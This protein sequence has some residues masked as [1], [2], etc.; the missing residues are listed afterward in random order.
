MRLLVAN[1]GEIAVRIM[2]AASELG[3]ETVA[4]YSEDDARALHPRRADAA[5]ALQ[6]AGA[7]AYLDVDQLLAAA[8]EHRC[9]A[10]HPGYGFLSEQA[11]FARACEDA[12]LT[13]VGPSPDS[14]TTF[15]DKAR[16][17]AL[18]ESLGVPVLRGASTAVSLE[19]AQAFLKSLGPGACMVIKAVAGGGGRG[20]RVV[21]SA[22]EVETAYARCR[23]EAQQA[24]GNGHVYVERL[25]AFARH[26]EVQ[27]LG[28]GEG[29]VAHLWERECSI[30]R[31]HQKIVEIAP[32]PLLHPAVRNRLLSD[33]IAMARMVS[34]RSAGTFEFLVDASADGPDAEYAFIEVN[35]RIQVEHTVTEELLDIDV[36]K[37]QLRV[38]QGA[39]LAQIG[40]SQEDIPAPRGYAI[41]RA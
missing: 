27:V 32:S 37:A 9:D 15:G 29:G 36:V 5:A 2:R 16:A 8:V 17:R 28:D 4:V 14:L 24:F 20:M 31:R 35:A 25:M 39:T 11:H 18:A 19:E 1:R 40:L 41:R 7:A 38:A 6:G 33:A 12:G 13:F 10:V 3:I 23:S 21:S 34:Y 26:V 30:Q 22:A